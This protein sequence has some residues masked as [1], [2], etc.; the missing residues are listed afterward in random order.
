M[1]LVLLQYYI[2]VVSF[3]TTFVT[4]C[5]ILKTTVGDSGSDCVGCCHLAIVC[6]CIICLYEF[7]FT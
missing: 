1:E 2:C 7:V 4:L 3:D 6:D 5:S